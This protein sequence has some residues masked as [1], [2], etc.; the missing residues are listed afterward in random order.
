MPDIVT[1]VSNTAAGLSGAKTFFHGERSFQNARD[2]TVFPIVYLDEP[3]VSN[4]KINQGGYFQWTYH[5]TVLFADKSE[6]DFTPEQQ[7][8][9]IYPMYKVMLEFINRLQANKAEV[10][11]VAANGKVTELKNLYDTNFSGVILEIDVLLDS[12]EPNCV[13]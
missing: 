5:I 7:H 3:I 10:Y 8:A 6:L 2:D 12:D 1:I 11:L 9:V 4:F 13:P